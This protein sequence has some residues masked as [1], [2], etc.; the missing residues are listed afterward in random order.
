MT[1]ESSD[2]QKILQCVDD[3]LEI[4]GKSNKQTIYY[5]LEKKVGLKKDEIPEDPET[6]SRG[7]ILMFGEE[8]ANIIEKWII[9]KLGQSF[10]LEKQPEMTFAKAINTIR[11]KQEH[12]NTDPK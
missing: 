9:E 2:A 8:G 5:H 6:F 7:L 1:E 11:T 3:G 12:N 4:L 10:H